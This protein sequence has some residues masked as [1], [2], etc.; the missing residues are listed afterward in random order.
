MTAPRTVG[1]TKPFEGEQLLRAVAVVL[2]LR[3]TLAD[4]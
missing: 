3:A 4:T 2:G 1:L